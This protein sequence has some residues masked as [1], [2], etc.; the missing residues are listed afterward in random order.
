MLYLVKIK[1]YKSNLLNY[2]SLFDEIW[3][4]ISYSLLLLLDEIKIEVNGNS[5]LKG[6]IRVGWAII[7]IILIFIIWNLIYLLPVKI[8]EIY[9]I[10]KKLILYI[11]GKF[12]KSSFI[13]HKSEIAPKKILRYPVYQ[14][15][16]IDINK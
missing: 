11:T 5:E 13:G 4:F 14:R 1:P 2:F 9:Q 8:I 3:L 10:T 6:S 12:I 7:G 16:N 15:S